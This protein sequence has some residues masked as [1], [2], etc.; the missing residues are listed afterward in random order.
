LAEPGMYVWFSRAEKEASKKVL[1]NADTIQAF[2]TVAMA[3]AMHRLA[4]AIEALG[5]DRAPRG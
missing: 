1:T 3:E 4:A 5:A 2:A